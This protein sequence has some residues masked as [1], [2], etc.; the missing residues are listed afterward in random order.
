M[1]YCPS[2]GSRCGDNDDY[3]GECGQN[4]NCITEEI[5]EDDSPNRLVKTAWIAIA[6]ALLTLA[7]VSFMLCN[8]SKNKKIIDRTSVGVA[9]PIKVNRNNPLDALKK[10]RANGKVGNMLQTISQDYKEDIPLSQILT[11]S[12]NDRTDR[13]IFNP[14][15]KNEINTIR[16]KLEGKITNYATSDSLNDNPAES[17]YGSVVVA[18][19]SNVN[20]SDSDNRI[21]PKDYNE[22]SDLDDFVSTNSG[23]LTEGDLAVADKEGYITTDSNGCAFFSTFDA[24]MILLDVGSGIS[25]SIDGS[26]LNINDMTGDMIVCGGNNNNGCNINI[27]GDQLST[28][29]GWVGAIRMY[30][31]AN[32]ILSLEGK[33]TLLSSGKKYEVEPMTCTVLSNAEEPYKTEAKISDMP[34]NYKPI[35][36]RAGIILNILANS[37]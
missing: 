6:L 18:L 8:N 13:N 31:D 30:K 20:C 4:L 9:V 3:C 24:Q 17:K 11:K 34:M 7:G 27:D 33:A 2:C 21:I 22:V 14:F 1:K 25:Y 15:T 37:L 12:M 36:E 10:D 16:T 28:E 19:S 5:I 32:T 23:P 29:P 35:I 26:K